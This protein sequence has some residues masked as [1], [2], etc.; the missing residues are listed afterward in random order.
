LI[1]L[2]TW[3]KEQSQEISHTKQ[4]L[5]EIKAR[6][7]QLTTSGQFHNC[8][9]KKCCA[10]HDKGESNYHGNNELIKRNKNLIAGS[11]FS[12]TPNI[13]QISDKEKI[14]IKEYFE[15]KKIFSIA[16]DEDK[17]IITYNDKSQEIVEINNSQLQQIKEVVENQPNQK[18]FFS[19]LQNNTANSSP[20]NNKLYQG[21]VIGVL[22]GIILVGIALIFIVRKKSSS[23]KN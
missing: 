15:T 12:N 16:L 23:K 19:E 20:N 3:A 18:L 8:G 21:L 10:E 1:Y 14:Q 17:L 4:I 11:N 5:A 7:D 9:I 6:L 13:K 22:S 2:E